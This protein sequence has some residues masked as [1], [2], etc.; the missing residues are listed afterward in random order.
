MSTVP[1]T[2]GDGLFS[3]KYKI[4]VLRRALIPFARLCHSDGIELPDMSAKSAEWKE[5]IL[6]ARQALRETR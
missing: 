1:Y 2:A 3:L 4:S 6:M 5:K